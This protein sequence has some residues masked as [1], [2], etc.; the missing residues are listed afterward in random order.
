[1]CVWFLCSDIFFFSL[2]QLGEGN[3]TVH[4]CP[5]GLAD[6][7]TGCMYGERRSLQSRDQTPSFSFIL[8]LGTHLLLEPPPPQ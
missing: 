1:M 8:A 7:P 4:I 2:S 6:W 5:Q 3:L